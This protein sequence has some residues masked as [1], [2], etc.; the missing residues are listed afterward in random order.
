MENLGPRVA[1]P[2]R[3]GLAFAAV[4]HHKRW[5]LDTNLAATL[6]ALATGGGGPTQRGCA[7]YLFDKL[8]QN[9]P[10]SSQR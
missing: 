10:L 3:I 7:Q 8:A 2:Q 5:E 1:L 4:A 6:A 9:C